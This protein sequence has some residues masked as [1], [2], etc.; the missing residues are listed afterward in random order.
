MLHFCGAN[1]IMMPN[2]VGVNAFLIAVSRGHLDIVMELLHHKAEVD[3]RTPFGLTALML[4]ASKDVGGDYTDIVRALIEA[5]ADIHLRENLGQS[6]LMVAANNNAVQ[7]C[8]VLLDYGA[9]PNEV[10]EGHGRRNSFQRGSPETQKALREYTS[11]VD[12][13]KKWTIGYD[14]VPIWKDVTPV[15]SRTS[16]ANFSRKITTAESGSERASHSRSGSAPSGEATS[17]RK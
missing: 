14:N 13:S 9:D 7:S 3:Y 5:G 11:K 1:D 17:S 16:T 12:T 2:I 10:S 6:A 15:G 8:Y 4:A